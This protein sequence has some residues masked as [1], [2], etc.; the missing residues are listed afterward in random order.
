MDIGYVFD[1]AFVQCAS[2]SIVS[3]LENNKNIETINFWIFD[4]GI[5]EES[6]KVLHELISKYQKNVYYIST[7]AVKNKLETMDLQLWRNKYS[8]YLKIMVASLLQDY[9]LE[10]IIMLD[11]DTIVVGKIDELWSTSL[12]GKIC[13]M[14]LEG[15]HGKYHFYT[16]LDDNELYNT[17]VILFDLNRWKYEGIEE[18]F[19]LYLK[20]VSAHYMLPEEDPL[21]IILAGK[22]KTLNLKYN[23]ITQFYIYN[24]LEYYRRF[25]WDRLYPHFYSL[26]EIQAAKEDVRIYHCIDTFTNRPWHANNCHPYTEIYDYY[27]YLTNWSDISK[28]IHK[29]DIK[30]R[31][32]YFLRKYLPEK[33][34]RYLYYLSAKILYTVGARR[35][36]NK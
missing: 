20:T 10:K 11:A 4:D 9:E 6:K 23:F 35:F 14:A 30:S 5:S 34:S 3:L 29:M 1:E 8:A 28:K 31:V 21:S 24:S 13:G 32:E 19:L 25:A 26:E 36:Y 27:L 15:I 2:V 16:G 22:V 12:D 17:G 18:K 7:T 33:I